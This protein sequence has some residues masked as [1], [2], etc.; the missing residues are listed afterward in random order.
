MN[1]NHGRKGY[2]A[3]FANVFGLNDIGKF[4]F[5]FVFFFSAA[6]FKILV[7]NIISLQGRAVV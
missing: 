4:C 2:P 6:D 1:V 7:H 5:M 3:I